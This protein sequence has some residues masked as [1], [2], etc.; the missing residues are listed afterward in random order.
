MMRKV[1]VIG[2]GMTRFVKPGENKRLDYPE[3]GKEA[4]EKALADA[5]ISYKEIEHANVGYVYGDSACGQRVLYQIGMT[6]I[7]IINVNNYCSTGSSALYLSKK[8]VEGG[9]VQCALALG[10]EKMSRGQL[11]SKFN[12]RTNPMQ[13]HL[14]LFDELFGI[15]T[16]PVTA[17]LFG[18]AGKEHM[19]KYGTRVEHFAKIAYKNH[20]HSKNNPYSQFRD[21]HSLQEIMSATSVRRFTHFQFHSDASTSCL[22]TSCS[23]RSPVFSSSLSL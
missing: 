9:L 4:V 11:T 1:Y 5:K 12:D 2:V 16:A 14:D 17:Q 19:D 23:T 13:T 22:S 3:M 15:K 21:E 8:L 7:T 10:F 18:Q 6:G 20:K